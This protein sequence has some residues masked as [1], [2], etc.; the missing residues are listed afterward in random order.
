MLLILV[1][2]LYIDVNGVITIAMDI[3][4]DRHASSCNSVIVGVYYVHLS[5]LRFI[6]HH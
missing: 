2:D 4:S 6:A 5:A 3:W 1:H